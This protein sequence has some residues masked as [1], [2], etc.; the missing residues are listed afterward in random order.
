MYNVI[1]FN[2]KYRS[3]MVEKKICL[4][5]RKIKTY[6]ELRIK[7]KNNKVLKEFKTKILKTPTLLT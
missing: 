3:F 6:Q 1:Y 5:M 4:K 2:A 7:K